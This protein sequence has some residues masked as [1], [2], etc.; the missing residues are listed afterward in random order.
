MWVNVSL[1][2]QEQMNNSNHIC[3]LFKIFSLNNLLSIHL[4][5]EKKQEINFNSG[6]QKISILNFK[7]DV[8]FR[9]NRKLRSTKFSYQIKEEQMSFLLEHIERNIEE[10]KK[11][12]ETKDKQL[13]ETKKILQGA[14]NSYQGLTKENKQ[15]RQYIA[16]IK[17][18]EQQQLE[19]QQQQK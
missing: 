13:T 10:Y 18:Q 11:I 4:I 1:N 9:M 12:I 8:F 15:L 6:E 17:Q 5:D 3:F 16:N 19:Q 14:K 2:E 7:I